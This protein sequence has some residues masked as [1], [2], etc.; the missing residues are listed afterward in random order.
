MLSK[1]DID[2]LAELARLGLADEEKAGLERDLSAILG[3]VDKLQE[4]KVEFT[5]EL[6]DENLPVNAMRED[7]E[8]HE[9]GLYTEAL[10][11][12]APKRKGD[13]L[14]VKAIIEK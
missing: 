4:A 8:P 7:G 5:D 14:V 1:S 13:Y 12:Q 3:Y 6:I 11:A 2:K 9:S 10:L